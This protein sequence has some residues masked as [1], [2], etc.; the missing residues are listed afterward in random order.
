MGKYSAV[1]KQ[2]IRRWSKLT[3]SVKCDEGVRIALPH[4]FISPSVSAG[5]FKADQFYWDSYFIILG[6]LHSGV[7]GL[8]TAKGMV[9]N[10]AYL[11]GRFG[12]IPSRNRFYNVGISQPP[13]LTS[14]VL[15]VYNK[16]QDAGWLSKM[17]RVAEGEY[18]DYWMGANHGW[19]MHR[20][21]MGLS[22]Y[23]DHFATHAT[24]EHESGWD[25][26]SRFGGRCLD[27]LPVDLNAC[28]YKYETDLSGA[29]G[30]LG[31][32]R[33]S[34]R[35]AEAARRRRRRMSKLFW[36]G[37]KG[38]FFDYDYVHGKRSG[39][40]SL[41]GYYPLWAGVATQAQAAEAA[42]N[43]GAFEERWG[44]ANTQR[45]C[46]SEGFNQWDYP[47]GWANQHWIVYQGL[48]NYGRKADARRI[49][50]KWLDLNVKVY[51][52]TRKFW[53]K[54]DVVHGGLGKVDRY[55]LQSGFGWT[56]GV[57]IRLAKELEHEE[58]RS[59]AA[60]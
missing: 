4:R 29:Y 55:P 19:R 5:I 21:H 13:F 37:R 50:V 24:A 48:M 10:F 33:A 59:R 11:Y 22:R 45:E 25:M 28:L 54:Y 44:L 56:N 47:N 1:V 9:E 17:M 15:E 58:P 39:F 40:Y 38:F 52:E 12:L 3:F 41:A 53:E 36:D 14:M 46:L 23:C 30:T 2:L 42:E 51:R 32:P 43:L 57:F 20:V 8:R 49:A 6:L 31:N 34:G 7:S 18:K 60:Y 16:T 26:T 35:Y 27:H